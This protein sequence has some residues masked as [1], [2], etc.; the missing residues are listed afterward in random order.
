MASAERIIDK[1]NLIVST[2]FKIVQFIVHNNSIY[3]IYIKRGGVP[4]TVKDY[5]YIIAPNSDFTS[6]LIDQTSLSVFTTALNF[7]NPAKIILYDYQYSEPNNTPYITNQVIGSNTDYPITTDFAPIA[8]NVAN[9]SLKQ[10]V[11]DVLTSNY[12]IVKSTTNT[13]IKN[14]PFMISIGGII[15]GGDANTPDNIVPFTTN[16]DNINN[17]II[18]IIITPVTTTL[19]IIHNTSNQFSSTPNFSHNVGVTLNDVANG[20]NTYIIYGIVKPPAFYYSLNLTFV[21]GQNYNFDLTLELFDSTLQNKLKVLIPA[22][23]FAGVP[24]I[25]YIGYLQIPK[26]EIINQY[27][28][29]KT[30]IVN[31]NPAGDHHIALPIWNYS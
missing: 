12:F 7:I 30:T 25:P 10:I 22:T 4:A 27:C 28:Y 21:S 17:I 5:D 16:T 1:S 6:G 9:K 15:G 29:V 11:N 23:N 13:Y 20:S 8:N 2:G 18:P 3:N 14:A 31:N 19:K 26:L 24:T